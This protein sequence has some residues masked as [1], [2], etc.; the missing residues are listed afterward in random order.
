MLQVAPTSAL[1]RSFDGFKEETHTG[2]DGR[3]YTLDDEHRQSVKTSQDFNNLTN[4]GQF[5]NHVQEKRNQRHKAQVQGRD[6]SIA[7]SGP[8]R[9]D[10]TLR[11]FASD[12][13]AQ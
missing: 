11:A 4:T 6:G 2:I 5:S 9:E 8:L 10:E 7:L 12:D 13:R 1:I 3:D